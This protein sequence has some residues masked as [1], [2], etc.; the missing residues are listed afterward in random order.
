MKA[1]AAPV[2]RPLLAPLFSRRA[3]RVC[4]AVAGG[5]RLGAAA[6]A[7]IGPHD[8]FTLA[9]LAAHAALD[10]S[11]AAR[12]A[13]VARG[14][15]GGSR[16]ARHEQHLRAGPTEAAE[17]R[18]D[19]HEHEAQQRRARALGGPIAA[20]PLLARLRLRRRLLASSRQLH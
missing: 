12:V 16:I 13:R 19:Q 5:R 15:A 18:C 10:A 6:A 20:G 14:A 9:A 3:G 2:P 7:R 8:A 11:R 17:E 4:A 1:L